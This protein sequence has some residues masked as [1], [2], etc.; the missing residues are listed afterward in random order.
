M[1]DKINIR[2]VTDVAEYHAC[3]SIQK[4]VWKFQDR[5][6]IPVNELITIQRS[7]GLVL[8]A[9][10]GTRM[11]GFAFGFMGKQAVGRCNESGG[12]LIHSSRMLAVLPE[13]RNY[14]IGFRLK[15][16]QRDFVLKQGIKLITWTFDPLQS[17]NGFFNLAKLGVTVS[18]YLVNLYGNSSSL[19]NKGVPTDRFVAEWDIASGRVRER[20]LAGGQAYVARANRSPETLVRYFMSRREE[21]VMS[22]RANMKTAGLTQSDRL[23]ISSGLSGIPMAFKAVS[24]VLKGK[25]NYVIFNRAGLPVS[26]EPK[27]NLASEVIFTEIPYDYNQIL[28]RDNGLAIDW[29]LK[30]RKI[31]TTYFGRGYRVVDLLS[32]RFP[33]ETKRTSL[34]ILRRRK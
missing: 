6:I 12:Q 20:L 15:V 31:F 7:G 21:K 8:G 27:L 26:A 9:F 14:D 2:P 32:P 34:Y 5:E 13:Y 19:L 23:E 3:E 30:T 17:L 33:G 4:Q 29:R 11:V 25:T 18:Q 22:A 1:K 24:K 28:H 10:V 16:A